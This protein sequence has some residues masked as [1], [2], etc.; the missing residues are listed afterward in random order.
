MAGPQRR[1]HQRDDLPLQRRK[2]KVLV[3][4]RK[5]TTAGTSRRRPL[6][7]AVGFAVCP[8]GLRSQWTWIASAMGPLVTST[9]KATGAVP[10]SSM[11]A[12]RYTRPH[13]GH[14]V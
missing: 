9:R 10:V 11:T 12:S 8:Y 6:H 5:R 3:A 14:S 2:E 13:L 7:F 4:Q 1:V